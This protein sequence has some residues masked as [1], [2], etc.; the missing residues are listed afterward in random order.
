MSTGLSLTACP[1]AYCNVVPGTADSDA[2]KRFTSEVDNGARLTMIV[3]NVKDPKNRAGELATRMWS[4]GSV[5]PSW[6]R[7]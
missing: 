6:A 7:A 4:R 3:D 1:G 2:T 5:I